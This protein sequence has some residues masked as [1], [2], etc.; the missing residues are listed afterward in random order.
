VNGDTAAS[1]TP[2]GFLFFLRQGTLFAQSFDF[3]KLEVTKEPIPIAEQVVTDQVYA[4]GFSVVPGIIAYR[5]GGSVASRQLTWFD[6]TGKTVGVVGEVDSNGLNT[7]DLSPDGRHVAVMRSPN[8]NTDIWLLDTARGIPTRFAFDAAIDAQPI[9]SPDGTRVVFS[10]NREGIFNLYSKLASNV[11]AE[12]LL[13]AT[14]QVITAND[15]SPDGRFVLFRSADP[16]NGYDLWVL[17]MFGE[18]KPIPFLATAFDERDGQF[19]PDGARV[20]YQSNESGRFEIYVQPFP[21]PGEKFQVSTG[22]GAQVR[23]RSDG[24]EIFF[25]SLDGKLMAA[26]V[27]LMPNNGS[28]EFGTPQPLFMTRV[29]GG[30]LPGLF[31]QQYSASA[32]G[33]RFLIN[34]SE[35]TS[36][37]PINVI[38]NWKPKGVQ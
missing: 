4:S 29:A 36:L 31:I 37:A 26:P 30:A 23:W 28:I 22:G 12:D 24:K 3:K 33:Q 32:D 25:I 13:L 8:S 7:V 1:M 15:W 27:K 34:V 21:G 17:P 2:A 11:A 10:S 5:P 16:K 14:D 35:G 9:W 19:S 18:K 38:Y 20:A 6:R